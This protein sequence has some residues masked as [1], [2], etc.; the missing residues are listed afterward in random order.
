MSEI[1][2]LEGFLN[3]T[4]TYVQHCYEEELDEDIKAAVLDL[5]EQVLQMVIEASDEI[6]D[7]VIGS[8]HQLIAVMKNESV[9]SLASQPLLCEGAGWRELKTAWKT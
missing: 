4:I 3:C 9:S 5:I 8:L 1:D 6:F 2:E 7:I